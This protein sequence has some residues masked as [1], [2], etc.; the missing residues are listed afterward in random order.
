MKFLNRIHQSSPEVS[1]LVGST[2]TID[3]SVDLKGGP[4]PEVKWSK[5]GIPL[6]SSSYR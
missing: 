5:D 4:V 2:Y 6:T 3:C 1:T